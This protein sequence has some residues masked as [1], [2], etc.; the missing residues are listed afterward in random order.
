[1]VSLHRIHRQ[2]W[3]VRA[4]DHAEAMRW[5]QSLRDDAQQELLAAMATV[6]DAFDEPTQSWHLP[7]LQLHLK[8]S[9]LAQLREQLPL[10]LADA[11]RDERWQREVAEPD[12]KA[13]GNNSSAMRLVALRHYLSTGQ[14][15]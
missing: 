10:A 4:G 7:R 14:L 13:A 9:S 12:S 15:C 5:R 8:V 11:L 2:R 3:Q 1:M 6:F